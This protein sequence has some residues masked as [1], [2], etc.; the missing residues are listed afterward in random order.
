MKM[1][2]CCIGL[3]SLTLLSLP[4]TASQVAPIKGKLA[5]AG[6][7]KTMTVTRVDQESREVVLRS[8]DGAESTFIAGPEV[9]NLAQVEAGDTVSITYMEAV[10]VR[11]YPVSAGAKGR[12]EK[13][14][15]SRAPLG[16]KPYGMITRQL[17]LTGQV[18]ELDR[19]TRVATLAGKH[20]SL[21]LR[22]AEDVNLSNIVVGDMV[23]VD[24][25]ERITI[26]VEAPAK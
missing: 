22:V 12:I 21:T 24:Y 4:A 2:K 8:G 7:T 25:L 20:G 16:A 14:E 3:L 17:E 6:V 9:R 19:E 11:V 18:A 10:A 26:S 15:I 1:S 23:R 13:R 5:A